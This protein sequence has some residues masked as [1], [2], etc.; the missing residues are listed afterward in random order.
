MDLDDR[1]ESIIN[2][3]AQSE[4]MN[5]V[6]VPEELARPSSFL[7]VLDAQHFNWQSDHFRKFFAMR[8]DV[9]I[10]PIKQINTIFYPREKYDTPIFIF[11]MLLTKRKAIAH[12]NIN[13]PFDDPDY[14]EKWQKPFAEIINDYDSFETKD[15]YPEW[16]KKYR[17]NCTIYGL[18]PKDRADDLSECCTRFLDLYMQK[19]TAA[20]PVTDPAR[21]EQIKAFH[22]Q[23]IDDIRTQDKAQSMIAKMIGKKT[24]KRIFYEVTT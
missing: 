20:E 10:P 6:D 9:K 17:S 15:R 14:Q 12:L 1:L 7:K 16:M 8:F 21:L 18:F 2:R 5:A 11:F 19:V 4:H 13:C 3:I 23:W 22:G 24:A